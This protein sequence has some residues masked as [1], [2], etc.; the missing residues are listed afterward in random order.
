MASEGPDREA[1]VM[2][3]LVFFFFFLPQTKEPTYEETERLFENGDNNWKGDQ[4]R[5]VS[6]SA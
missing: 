2:G 3:P 6:Q 5:G 1:H 4:N